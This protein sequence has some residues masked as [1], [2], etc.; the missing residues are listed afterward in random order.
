MANEI[1]NHQKA[2]TL[3]GLINILKQQG[4]NP[5]HWKRLK[6]PINAY[7]AAKTS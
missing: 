5:I 4:E 6:I 1:I 7:F 3:F 2:A